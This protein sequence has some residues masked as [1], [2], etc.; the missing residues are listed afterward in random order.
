VIC[1]SPALRY[2]L[3]LHDVDL[4]ANTF[5]RLDGLMAGALLAVIVR[6]DTF[7]PSRYVRP[8][9][10]SFLGA[11]SLAFATE[12]LH[13]RWIV[14]SLTAVASAAFV[15]LGLFSTHTWLQAALR[16]RF[17]VYTGTISYGLYLLHKIPVDVAKV[18]HVDG[19]SGALP[20]MLVASYAMAALSWRWFEQPLLGLK[21][22]FESD[23]IRPQHLHRQAIL[24]PRGTELD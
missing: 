19:Y 3:S 9:I 11:A 8:A 1:L 17:L 15:Y 4:Y 23:P 18:L 14:F 6:S 12:A 20:V 21:R 24:V 13:A 22:F 2:W 7:R 16:N 5:C 10:V